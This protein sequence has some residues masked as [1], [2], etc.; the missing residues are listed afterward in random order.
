M[1][2]VCHL[3][4]LFLLTTKG[5]QAACLWVV[6]LLPLLCGMQRSE[7]RGLPPGQEGRRCGGESGCGAAGPCPGRAAGSWAG[8]RPHLPTALAI[9]ILFAVVP[10]TVASQQLFWKNKSSSVSITLAPQPFVTAVA[11]GLGFILLKLSLADQKVS[12]SLPP[13]SN[14]IFPWEKFLALAQWPDIVTH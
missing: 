2:S 9:S 5:G 4:Q 1:K 7:D 12:I 11:V 13:Y 10:T 3:S 8:A 6:L 14:T